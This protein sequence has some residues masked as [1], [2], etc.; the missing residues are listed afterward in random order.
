M[1]GMGKLCQR[2]AIA[3]V[4]AARDGT[5]ARWGPWAV[6]HHAAGEGGI[7]TGPRAPGSVSPS[8]SPARVVAAAPGERAKMMAE[9][10]MIGRTCGPS[11]SRP[12]TGRGSRQEVRE[13]LGSGRGAAA[14]TGGAI[15]PWIDRGL[16]R[17]W[18][19]PRPVL[20]FT[21]GE[22]SAAPPAQERAHTEGD[23][24]IGGW[25]RR[26]SLRASPAS[27]CG[28][29]RRESGRRP[30]CRLADGPSLQAG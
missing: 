15:R 26:G 11:L 25:T 13:I 24:A 5:D 10:F 21:L 4:M 20:R 28:R 12:Q 8:A 14:G 3:G 30:R 22:R 18:E 1:P 27:Q 2:E 19:P 9:S 16:A 23:P 17:P 7:A 29:R 6:S